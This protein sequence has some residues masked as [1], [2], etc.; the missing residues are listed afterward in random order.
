M[1]S[2]LATTALTSS[3]LIGS[4]LA[5]NLPTG[6]SVAAG[7][8]AIAQPSSTQLN[9]TQT[10][11]SAI[12]N[13]QS[14]SIGQG[15]SV[16]I[17]QPNSTS[18][19][20]NRV[21]GNAPS[22]IAGSLTANGQVYLV[23]PN[24]IAITST[25]VVNAAG[26]F[27]ASTLGISDADF[28]SGKRSFSG[29]GASAAVSNAGLIAVGRG[30]YA[31]LLG[32]TVS[33]AGKIIVPLGKVGLGSGESATLDFSG[34]GFLQVALP[35]AAGGNGALI[36][37]SGAIRANGGSVIISAATAREAARNAVNISGL[38]EARSI[39]G[40]SGSIFIGGGAGGSVN[41]S[42]RLSATGHQTAGGAIAVTGQNIALAGATVDASGATGG[43]SI[44]IGGGSHGEGPLQQA[45]TVSI[46]NQT[47]I[48]ADATATG[49]GGNVVVWSNGSTG[50]RGLIT[51]TGGSGGGNGGNVE[52]SGHSVDFI[53]VRVDTSAPSGRSGMWLVDPTNLTVDAA[54]AT[55]ISNNLATTDVT[56]QTNADG[57]TSGTGVT[58]NGA[59]D[60]IVNSGISWSSNHLLN[61]TAYNA[62]TINAPINITGGGGLALNAAGQAGVTTTG[63]TFGNGASIDYGGTNHGGTFSL[64]GTSY[65][66]VYSMAQLDAIDGVSAVN[67]TAT[68]TYGA[69]LAG[70]YALATNLNA[71]GTTYTQALIGTNSSNSAATQFVGQFD[72]LGHT[73][74]G[75]TISAPGGANVGLIGYVTGAAASVSN[76]G[77]VGGSMIGQGNT[78]SL[79]ASLD[80]GVVQTS[81]SSA[82]VTGSIS[83]TG[84][85]IGFINVG[86]V[87][88][89][90]ASGTVV[91]GVATGGL[92][93]AAVTSSTIINSYATGAVSGGSNTGG[94]IGFNAGNV[95]ASYATGAVTGTGSP[96]SGTGGL[97][98]DNQGGSVSASYA[99]GAVSSG[100]NLV[101]GLIGAN[102]GNVNGSHATGAVT[103]A[104]GTG[105]LIGSLMTGTVNASY[106]TGAVTGITNTGGLIGVSSAL[107]QASYATGA[108]KSTGPRSGG[109][110]GQNSGGIVQTSYATGAVSSS[111]NAVGGLVGASSGTVSSSYATGAVSAGG[112]NAGGLIGNLTGGAVS[113]SYSTGTVTGLAGSA[114]GLIGGSTGPATVSTSY[115]DT[116][117]SGATF[118]AAG[119]GLTTAQ[120]QGVLQAGFSTTAW[121]TGSGLYPYL[122]W[123]FAAGTTPQS[124]SGIASQANGSALAGVTIDATVNGMA[125]ANTGTGANGYYYF[126]LP[127]G[128]TAQG[129]GVF[130]DIA[131]NAVKAND[132]VQGAGGS[133]QNLNLN[134]GMMGIVTGAGALSSVASGLASAVGGLPTT[135][136]L[137]TTPG[138]VLTP[139]AGTSVSI[140]ASGAFSVDQ[141]L[142]VPNALLLNAAGNLTIASTGSLSSANGNVTLVDGS[143]FINNAGAAAVSAANGRWLIYSADPLNDSDGG[144]VYN[145]KQYG[146]SYGATA[147]AQATGNG[148]LYSVTPTIGLT[149]TA[150]KTY[151]GN[152]GVTP[153]SFSVGFTGYD[154]D[155]VTLTY[156]NLV[157]GDVNAGTGKTVTANGVAVTSATNG[158]V[159]VY[160]YGSTTTASGTIG[161]ITPRAITVA[162]DA[163]SRVYGNANPALSYVVGGGG[164]V[165]GDS[166]TGSLATSATTATGIGGYAI[167]QGTLGN[168]N[169]ALSYTGANL[170][171]TARPLTVTADAQSRVYGDANPTLTYGTGGGLVNGDSLS[172]SLAT[173]AT[174]ATGIGGYAITQGTLG[175]S[176]YAL[177][178][179]GANLTITARP[180]TVTADAQSRVYGDAN[181]TLTYGTAGGLVNGDSLTGSLAT[182][183]AV[184]TGVGNYS[185]MQGSLA[186]NSNYA[187]TYVGASLSITAR[188]LTVTADAQSRVYGD[189]NPALSYGTGGGLV[190]GDSLTGSLATGATTATGV[191]SYTITQGTLGNSNYALTY[192]GA[193]LSIT[194]RPLTV[195]ADG[196]SRVYGD[197]NPTLTYAIGGSGLVNGDGLLGGLATSATN[198]TGV[199]SYN[200]TQGSLAASSN[201]ALTYTGA[202]LAINARP[203]TVTA[204]AQSQVYGDANPTLTYA[205]GGRGL[206]NGDSLSGSLATTATNLTG[207]GSYGITQ[208]NLAASSNYALTYTG[209]N[210]AI[211]ARPLTVTA[212][213]QTQIYGDASPPLTYVI[214]GRGLV[215]GDGLFGGL[216]TSATSA[217][218]TTGVG[219]YG[220]T[221]GNLAA[222]SNY[223]LTYTGANLT[224]TAR[225]LTVTADG[226]SRVYGDA[227]P[228]LSYGTG[229]GL[230][231]G[232]SLTGSLVTSATNTTGIGSYGITQ[233]SLGNSNYAVT[234]IGASLSITARPITVTADNGQNR[235]YGDTN[236]ML[237]YAIGSGLV[238]GD[239]LT[240]SLATSATNT[241]GVGN[242]AITRGS[243]GN[244]NYAV[245]YI[246]ANLAI[247][248]RSITVTADALAKIVGA[249]NPDLTYVVGGKGLV[250]G[251]SLAGSLA[252]DATTTSA[253]GTYGITQGTVTNV[254][255]PNYAIAYA[256]ANL[257]VNTAPPAQTTPPATTLPVIAAP[258]DPSPAKTATITIQAD[259]STT[260]VITPLSTTSSTSS[261]SSTRGAAR[262]TNDDDIVT[263]SIDL[264]K[265]KKKKHPAP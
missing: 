187:L 70:A 65:T 19:M 224:V 182:N 170:T 136:L 108:V 89:S 255:N 115:W 27:V 259:Q 11:Q 86:T 128:S 88:S 114:G 56:L 103:G 10:S 142:V 250:N 51:A 35:T 94:L 119:T 28:Q 247:T 140:A 22:S 135:D 110:I 6:G 73:V 254:L 58:S 169:Y 144:L 79:V 181:P 148:V 185:I 4:A 152:T 34:D 171:I 164:L 104:S 12:V 80:A 179:T 183:A 62:I 253:V 87:Q 159:I 239:Q 180:L 124:L 189:A 226:Q 74:T 227:N 105:G 50:V 196:Q 216:A 3:L 133:V 204:D 116:Q 220:I 37:N 249:D 174:T 31:A 218:N 141:N 38:V 36:S 150:S 98:G 257:T 252:T 233:G 131:G 23:N 46:D 9:I 81:F 102:N 241:T 195:T 243:L 39:G 262:Q 168:S 146:A 17:Q 240:G 8:V 101:G 57:T 53:G 64:N 238:N 198:T 209:A 234:Y 153:G 91:G 85:L 149:G 248:P 176:N 18:A 78:G 72:G 5:Q 7:G 246:G 100:G 184:T 165:S 106:A 134:A 212:D 14:F 191:G 177:N 66:L 206:V 59:G 132:Y 143:S 161:T 137:F 29:N 261:T 125:F 251:D 47:K 245:T 217:T 68:A 225:P 82:K 24:G 42:G 15:S 138:G 263:G 67:N 147:V 228:T 190:N 160:G 244:S 92:V 63:L 223:A 96:I 213:A 256:G 154:Q 48:R 258:S 129:S 93:G 52:T 222:S 41:V 44:N 219:G 235:A 208:G 112:I 237:T 130:I 236:P 210:L 215:N 90:Y 167:T 156:S 157:Y 139:N 2:L 194:A 207:V 221:Q 111:M 1:A 113:S 109:L 118:S 61:L 264:K 166:L 55:T 173:G 20:L 97:I 123:Q 186:A 84:G 83:N 117:T 232:D 107:V 13:W 229:G 158:G 155:V 45:D 99:S 121:S 265:K 242:Y 202:N 151:D 25:G 230:V 126:L 203:L 77:L 95:V 205:T 54:S 60:I 16:N 21:T 260:A 178:Y 43:G 26:A 163:Q 175:N 120:L 162:A 122:T 33:N 30:G 188:P 211:T 193:S 76:I 127:Q 231:N 199:G 200:I 32:G 197:A 71:S 201:Y 40:Q 75:L 214:G 172:G 145:F 192:V 49:N 69:G